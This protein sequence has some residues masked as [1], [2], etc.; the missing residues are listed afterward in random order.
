MIEK[1]EQQPYDYSQDST[2]TTR[3]PSG[4]HIS[5]P[6]LTLKPE[7]NLIKNNQSKIDSLNN[8]VN[9]NSY[10]NFEMSR[11]ACSNNLDDN[12][13]ER[14]EF[15]MQM[16]TTPIVRKV[17]FE[18]EKIEFCNEHPKK[19]AKYFD[20]SYPAKHFCSK[21]ALDI[22]INQNMHMN[23]TKDENK[24]RMQT[25]DF[26]LRLSTM[27]CD[28]QIL[29]QRIQNDIRDIENS[30]GK[31][32]FYLNDFFSNI[33]N[34]IQ[35]LLISY[36]ESIKKSSTSLKTIFTKKEEKLTK[37]EIEM[38]ELERDVKTNYTN[39]VK[40][41]DIEPFY[42]IMHRY[43]CKLNKIRHVFLG[44][45]NQPATIQE[46]PLRLNKN[47]YIQ[48]SFM[49]YLVKKV[50]NFQ[51]DSKDS[52]DEVESNVSQLNINDEYT[53]KKSK[54]GDESGFND[55]QNFT[56]EK[57]L[58]ATK[59]K[60]K[61]CKKKDEQEG[62]ESK[63]YYE[64][65][66]LTNLM[67]ICISSK[68]MSRIDFSGD[69]SELNDK[70][71]MFTQTL[72]TFKSRGHI[73]MSPSKVIRNKSSTT[74][75]SVYMAKQDDL[76]LQAEFLIKS[77]DSLISNRDIEFLALTQSSSKPKKYYHIEKELQSSLDISKKNYLER[78]EDY[79]DQHQC[80]EK[81]DKLKLEYQK[82]G[83]LIRETGPK[84]LKKSLISIENKCSV[85]SKSADKITEQIIKN[86]P[87][88]KS[89]SSVRNINKEPQNNSQPTKLINHK[90]VKK[91]ADG[92]TGVTTLNKFLCETT[93]NNND[94]SINLKNKLLE[95]NFTSL[96]VNKKQLIND[97]ENKNNTINSLR[98][99]VINLNKVTETKLN[100]RKKDKI[101]S[102]TEE[103]VQDKGTSFYKNKLSSHFQST[104]NLTLAK[105][106]T[107]LDGEFRT[108]ETQ[109]DSKNL[110]R[111]FALTHNF[112]FDKSTTIA[113][114][115]ARDEDD[116]KNSFPKCKSEQ[117]KNDKKSFNDSI[118]LNKK[119]HTKKTDFSYTD[120]AKT[121][122]NQSKLLN[123]D[124]SNQDKLN[125]P[126]N[127]TSQKTDELFKKLNFGTVVINKNNKE[128]NSLSKT[129]YAI[130]NKD[131]FQ[132]NEKVASDDINLGKLQLKN[133][134]CDQSQ[135]SNNKQSKHDCLIYLYKKNKLQHDKP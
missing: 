36:S 122:R 38:D 84:K 43:N 3:N 47:H 17:D 133:D 21:C 121:T 89:S 14:Y 112:F 109:D 53:T 88:N 85:N 42:E 31:Q 61:L 52:I 46:N 19:K 129:Q 60:K 116:L 125:F 51:S 37:F 44:L 12:K 18:D 26:L 86:K 55:S 81:N 8:A 78:K 90:L 80:L 96:L 132:T 7:Q 68:K 93:R 134:Q 50:D 135:Q 32:E 11:K 123:F 124:S 58:E 13:S 101:P 111:P 6:C 54:D 67:P 87:M 120:K 35:D 102:N 114:N 82:D 22:F 59:R 39:I 95:N 56:S 97:S 64:S 10:E 34:T 110:Q 100:N 83:K 118:N 66:S 15:I 62:N 23:L 30:K 77:V 98:P 108:K 72:S 107:M 29:K 119:E 70:K 105:S 40:L 28:L 27:N 1:T 71:E 75:D 63:A 94:K 20:I 65:L 115:M 16:Q 117:F 5:S 113:S 76:K 69:T 33:K 104:V 25:E 103:I 128:Y 79:Y 74:K 41:M 24:K 92:R 91:R 127:F 126:K 48:S 4:S 73:S 45:K 49:N 9:E 99:S 2:S 57:N 106:N 130:S 131:I